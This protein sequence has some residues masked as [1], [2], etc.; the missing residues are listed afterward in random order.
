MTKD[1]SEGGDLF[2]RKF[3]AKKNGSIECGGKGAATAT[4]LGD[5][6][7][8]AGLL[9]EVHSR[10][11]DV[12]YVDDEFCLP[13]HTS[14]DVFEVAESRSESGD[15]ESD[16]VYVSRSTGGIYGYNDSGSSVQ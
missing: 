9:L 6:A 12:D 13:T 10:N 16:V 4:Y 2:Y 7:C 8:I 1:I 14:N 5:D 11:T 15:E 3:Q